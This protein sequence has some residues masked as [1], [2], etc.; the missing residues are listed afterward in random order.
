MASFWISFTIFLV[1]AQ[2]SKAIVWQDND[3]G[4]VRWAMDCNFEGNGTSE[5]PLDTFEKCGILCQET[6]NCDHFTWRNDQ[7]SKILYFT[8]INSEFIIPFGT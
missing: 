3:G 2:F 1:L 6:R 5:K 7:V 4:P 8:L